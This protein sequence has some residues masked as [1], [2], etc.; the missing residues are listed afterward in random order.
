MICDDNRISEIEDYDESDDDED[1]GDD[2]FFI[3]DD[4]PQHPLVASSREPHI[5]R[6]DLRGD[7]DAL[8][9]LRFKKTTESYKMVSWFTDRMFWGTD[10]T[11]ALLTEEELPSHLME[12]C[13]QALHN[14]M[15]SIITEPLS[16]TDRY[17]TVGFLTF[18]MVLTRQRR[19]KNKR[20][21]F[22][23]HGYNAAKMLNSMIYN[24]RMVI[25]TTIVCTTI[26]LESYW[27]L[28]TRNTIL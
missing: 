20:Y 5:H 14:V 15:L 8:R 23:L 3:A 22:S 4:E 1:D 12:Y 24:F 26:L 17:E 25:W 18:I 2:E 6:Q 27:H 9:L 11:N 16:G 28:T 19:I 7:E 21:S 10:L 13:Q